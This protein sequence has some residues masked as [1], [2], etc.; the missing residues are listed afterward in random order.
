MKQVVGTL[1][2]FLWFPIWLGGTSQEIPKK[3]SQVAVFD[4]NQASADELAT[5]P[6]IGPKLAGQIVA[7]REKHG[8]YRRVEDLLALRGIGPKKWKAIRPHLRITPARARQ[9]KA[10]PPC[11]RSASVSSRDGT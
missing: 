4:V 1:A 2:A 6:G 10:D 9:A 5:L 8:P 7:F 3:R 11:T